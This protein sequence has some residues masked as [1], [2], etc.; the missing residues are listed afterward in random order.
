VQGAGWPGAFVVAGI[1]SLSNPRLRMAGQTAEVV[2]EGDFELVS[3]SGSVAVNGAHLHMCIADAHGTVWGG[4]VVHGNG[5]RT[6]AEILLAP[7]PAWQLTRALDPANGYAEL[8]IR[9][10]PV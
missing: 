7:L 10:L 8:Q 2:F 6:T 9:R 4:H 1:G 3:L 5:V